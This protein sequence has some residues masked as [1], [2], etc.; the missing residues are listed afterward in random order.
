VGKAVAGGAVALG[1]VAALASPAYASA[2]LFVSPNGLATGACATWATACTISHALAVEAGAPAGTQ[3]RLKFGTYAASHNSVINTTDLAL[4]NNG[5]AIRGGC[6]PVGSTGCAIASSPTVLKPGTNFVGNGI[7]DFS[8]NSKITVVGLATNATKL[9]IDSTGVV[10]TAGQAPVLNAGSGATADTLSRATVRLGAPAVAV[11]LTNGST[12]LSH[13]DV[14]SAYTADGI[15][16]S[17]ST[18]GCTIT[19][20]SV[21]GGGS[22]LSKTGIML[23]GVTG[24]N[25]GGSTLAL[26]NHVSGNGIGIDVTSGPGPTPSTANLIEHNTI[27]G[28]IA[29]GVVIGGGGSVPEFGGTTANS[30]PN[31]L[32][33]NVWSGNGSTSQ[34]QGANVVDFPENAE[35]AYGT[36]VFTLGSSLAATTVPTSLSILQNGSGA[37]T[38]APGTILRTGGSSYGNPLAPNAA[39]FYVKSST[40]VAA[41]STPTSVPVTEI[42]PSLATTF[43]S[44]PAGSVV[45]AATVGPGSGPSS[46][47]TSNGPSPCVS[48]SFSGSSTLDTGT[49]LLSGGYFAC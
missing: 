43:A 2:P 25:I 15:L 38:L 49:S 48:P 17:G 41:G 11:A 39:T 21:N 24:Q 18:T 35:T 31:S 14:T 27:T 30:A 26:G 33:G 3:I 32:V 36:T 22:S 13:V 12:T 5:V 7:V 19:Q 37:V 10:Y 28:N 16:C 42:A 4:G 46:T 8:K 34:A 9:I 44:I 29:F 40:S 6:M 23:Q 20:S 45:A 1:S 47:Y